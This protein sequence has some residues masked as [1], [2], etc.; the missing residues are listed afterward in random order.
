MES[1]PHSY[2]PSHFQA[3]PSHALLQEVPEAPPTCRKLLR[4]S[5]SHVILPDHDRFTV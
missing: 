4:L 5:S 1:L 2:S 3:V